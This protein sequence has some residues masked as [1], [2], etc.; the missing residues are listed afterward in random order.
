MTQ[1]KSQ[2]QASRMG[3]AVTVRLLPPGPKCKIVAIGDDGTLRINLT[4]KISDK[5]ANQELIRFLADILQIEPGQFEIVA[6]ITG[7]DKLIAIS[8]IDSA[9]V[10]QRVLSFISLDKAKLNRRR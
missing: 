8:G 2:V 10:D 1:E 3:S 7:S 5:Q 9:A 4:V 6:G